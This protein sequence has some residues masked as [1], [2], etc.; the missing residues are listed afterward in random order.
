M[1]I[2]FM[3]LAIKSG[4][5]FRRKKNKTAMLN[6]KN[7]RS[8]VV[9]QRRGRGGGGRGGENAMHELARRE[10]GNKEERDCKGISKQNIQG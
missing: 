8:F 5:A 6:A 3:G 7:T 4:G 10:L 1:Y 2:T 9:R